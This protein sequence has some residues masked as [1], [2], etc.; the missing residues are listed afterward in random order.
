MS[1]ELIPRYELQLDCR[2][3]GQSI[4]SEVMNCGSD[5]TDNRMDEIFEP[6]IDSIESR[7]RDAVQ[8]EIDE[9]QGKA[10]DNRKEYMRD[11]QI[12]ER[13]ANIVDKVK[14]YVNGDLSRKYTDPSVFKDTGYSSSCNYIEDVNHDELLMYSSD[15]DHWDDY[16]KSYYVDFDAAATEAEDSQ[17]LENIFNML[18]NLN[19]E[20]I[21]PYMRKNSLDVNKIPYYINCLKDMGIDTY[22]TDYLINIIEQF[23]SEITNPVCQIVIKAGIRKGSICGRPIKERSCC[24]YH[25]KR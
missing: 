2:S 25:S 21:I 17:H 6:L 24:L 14:V 1:T 22:R 23:R 18:Y 16:R 10:D 11:I 8:M 7:T 12:D 3:A 5:I 19:E 4:V 20:H 13:I 15:D 9:M